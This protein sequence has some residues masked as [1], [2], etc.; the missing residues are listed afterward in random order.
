MI[1]P[2]SVQRG[3]AGRVALQAKCVFV[4]SYRS[5]SLSPT[6]VLDFQEMTHTLHV[7]TVPAVMLCHSPFFFILTISLYFSCIS[8]FLMHLF[9]MYTIH[10]P[11]EWTRQFGRYT[12]MHRT[13]QRRLSHA[14]AQNISVYPEMTSSSS[15]WQFFRV[16]WIPT[17][18]SL[19]FTVVRAERMVL[20]K[21]LLFLLSRLHAFAIQRRQ[22]N[23]TL[24][25]S[26]V[27]I[28][29]LL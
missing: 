17:S 25:S 16:N 1:A 22:V 10:A 5:T 23:H 20:Y 6:L 27:R 8:I 19:V 28:S 29:F 12:C 11:H 4:S 9:Y 18:F 13:A 24:P 14:S 15:L 21:A 26:I 2:G 7:N 3:C